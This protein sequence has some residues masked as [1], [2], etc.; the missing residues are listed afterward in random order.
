MKKA[1]VLSILGIAAS[2][3][4]PSGKV[5]F[6]FGNYPRR[7][8]QPVYYNPSAGSAPAGLAGMNAN[9]SNAEIQLFYVL[10]NQTADTAAQFLADATPG[11]DDLYHFGV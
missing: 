4:L 7:S 6:T 8:Y 2:G 10:G 1:I 11:V 5:P 9:N 3:L